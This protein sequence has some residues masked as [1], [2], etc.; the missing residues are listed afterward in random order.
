MGTRHCTYCAK[1]VS[2]PEFRSSALTAHH[3]FLCNAA[4]QSQGGNRVNYQTQIEKQS[5]RTR[6][7][8]QE[9][10]GKVPLQQVSFAVRLTEATSCQG[11]PERGLSLAS[12]IVF[13]GQPT[14]LAVALIP[15]PHSLPYPLPPSE[16]TFLLSKVHCILR[17]VH[18]LSHWVITTY[19]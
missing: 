18:A 1:W 4:S 12:L 17:T 2:H 6:L 3:A 10:T 19:L 5:G 7:R 11:V 14:W 13:Q 15:S 16:N 9:G 8:R